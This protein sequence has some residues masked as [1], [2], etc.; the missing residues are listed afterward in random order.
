MVESSDCGSGSEVV[1]EP[2]LT[3]VFLD[4]RGS[5]HDW[6]GVFGLA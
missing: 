2:A 5:E 4:V 3:G 6:R 1:K